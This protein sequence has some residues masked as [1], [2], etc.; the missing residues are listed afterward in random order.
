MKLVD[1]EHLERPIGNKGKI[2]DVNIGEGSF[3][4]C[5]KMMYHGIPVAV[6]QF[7]GLSSLADVKKEASILLK[8]SSPGIPLLFGIS[9]TKPYLLIM[10]FYCINGQ[11][12]TLRRMLYSTTQTLSHQS[13]IKLLVDIIDSLLFIHGNS[14]IHRDLKS[15]NIV[16]SYYNN[17]YVPV[18]IDFGKC[19][20]VSE[21]V[22]CK[23][24]SEA[25]QLLYREKYPHIAPE[26]VLGSTPSFASD[27]YS[28]GLI[29]S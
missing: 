23:E 12:Y 27:V 28:L 7:K 1:R 20:R 5:S 25:E 4:C 18:I 22:K 3:G 16:V 24:L 8:L 10:N 21:D 19:I 15:D 26:I 11:S 29:L 2:V 17:K 9:I 14:F 6:K 13:W